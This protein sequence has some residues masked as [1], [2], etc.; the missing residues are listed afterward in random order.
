MI[1]KRISVES[2]AMNMRMLA[3]CRYGFY[4][5]VLLFFYG[6]LLPFNLEATSHHLSQALSNIKLVPFWD[7]ERGRIHSLTDMLSNVLLTAPIGFFGALW[8]GR[9]KRRPGIAKWFF[10]GLC[11]GH[12]TREDIG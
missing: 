7:I 2:V 9:E 4:L 6:T 11:F 12:P 10:I 5:S 8:F 3:L 1:F